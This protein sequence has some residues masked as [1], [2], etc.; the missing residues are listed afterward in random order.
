MTYHAAGDQTT[1]SSDGHITTA[2][3]RSCSHI[4][5][6]ESIGF[7]SQVDLIFYMLI[8]N[9]IS[10]RIVMF[11]ENCFFT[12]KTVLTYGEMNGKCSTGNL[13]K[14][15]TDC[16]HA[17]AILYRNSIRMQVFENIGPFN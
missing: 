5:G 3:R 2:P 9:Q 7:G 12:L 8:L 13:D 16:D 4:N 15:Q 10:G 6:C 1:R 14:L 11:L 17:H